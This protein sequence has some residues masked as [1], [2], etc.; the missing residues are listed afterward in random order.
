MMCM[1]SM[2]Y[3][4]I[5]AIYRKYSIYFNFPYIYMIYIYIFFIY[6]IPRTQ[7]T[8]IF[9]GQP[10]KKRPVSIKTGVIW[11]LGVYI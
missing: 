3:I 7:L 6:N 11:V 10:S 8:L 1:M 9:E 5:F 2:I 4:Y